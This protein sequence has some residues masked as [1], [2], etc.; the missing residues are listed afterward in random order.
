VVVEN[1]PG[2]SGN[3]AAE[4]VAKSP[5]DGY[6]LLIV[7]QLLR[8]EPGAVRQAALRPARRFCA[9]HHGGFGASMIAVH[10]SVA[11]KDLREL[12]ALGKARRES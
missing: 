1:R 2:A 11:A 7:Q 6:T 12:V 5:A 9:G 8:H 4:F 10:P 3:I